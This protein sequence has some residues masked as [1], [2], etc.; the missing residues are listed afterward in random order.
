MRSKN[1]DLSFESFNDELN[2][3][4]WY[5][6]N[7]L[8]NNVI[9]ILVFDAFKDISLEFLDEFGLLISEDVFKSLFYVSMCDIC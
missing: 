5:S 6:L 8:L 4:S 1:M 7:G 9:A 3:L 2:V